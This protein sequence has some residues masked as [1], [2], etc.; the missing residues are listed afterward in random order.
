MKQSRA[1]HPPRQARSRETLRRILKATADLL[2]EREFDDITVD[3]IVDQAGSSKGS[4]YQ[5]FPDKDSL[6]VHLL[7][8]EH[9]AAVEM[10]ST[11]LDVSRWQE[12]SLHT[13]LDAF[14]DRLMEMYR[15]RPP[16]MRSYAGEVLHGDGEIR[17]LSTELNR[18]VLERLRRIVRE[19]SSEVGHPDP[20][21]ATAFLF[22]ALITLLP[23]LFLSPTPDFLPEPMSH[24][25]ME[26]EVRVLVRSYL[27][28]GTAS[29][30]SHVSTEA[31]MR[32][33]IKAPGLTMGLFWGGAV[34]VVGLA[35]L[36]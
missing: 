22:T 28:V 9:R 31:A 11:F 29:S 34:I 17:S 20:E 35:N 1:L 7:K 26:R 6:L 25:L 36:I 27:G 5:R 18:H 24:D 2:R 15:G 30:P 21:R 32:L 23:P 8:E 3:D 33:S 16:F 4:F 14:I 12:A 19:K 10:W 13:V